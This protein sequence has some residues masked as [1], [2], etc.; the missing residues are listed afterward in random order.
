MGS[1]AMRGELPWFDWRD[2]KL[3]RPPKVMKLIGAMTVTS[4]P[5][6]LTM[7]SELVRTT[8][9]NNML[10]TVSMGAVA[11]LNIRTQAQNL[12]G[13]LSA[14][15]AQALGPVAAMSTAPLTAPGT[16]MRPMILTDSIIS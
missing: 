6:V 16:M 2:D 7:V 11:A 9:L 15:G 14:G 5:V 10:V 13:A 8:I 3:R 4:A 12:I 1:Q